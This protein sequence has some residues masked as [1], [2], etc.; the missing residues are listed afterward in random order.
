MLR[1]AVMLANANAALWAI[2]SGLAPTLLITYL[3]IGHGA[4]GLGMSFVLAAPRFAGV[5]RLATPQLM[6]RL[7][8]PKRLCVLAYAASS[9][10]LGVA[11]I[12]PARVSPVPAG[13][14]LAVLVAAWA[15]YQVVEYI[16]TTSLWVWLGRI[17]PLPLRGRLIGVREQWLTRGQIVGAIAGFCLASSRTSPHLLWWL[18]PLDVTALAGAAAMATAVLPLIAMPTGSGVTP[19]TV[20]DAP[21]RKAR[22]LTPEMRNLLV[23]SVLLSFANG[24]AAP[25]RG[26]M[27]YRALGMTY[28]ALLALATVMRLGQ[29]ICAPVL[30]AYADRLGARPVIAWSQAVVVLSPLF[31]LLASPSSPWW[32]AG[33]Y[34]CWIAYAGLNV[35]L[36]LLKL[37]VAP[38]GREARSLALYY[39]ANDLASGATIIAGGLLLQ[40]LLNG[41]TADTSSYTW[42]LALGFAARLTVGLLAPILPSGPQKPAPSVATA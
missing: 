34:A 40:P 7:G 22:V 12:V 21:H 29:S 42:L 16:G 15:A 30:G 37:Q 35:G 41:S 19:A 9:L 28:P 1:R 14:R 23:W 11:A 4:Q 10:L 13:S 38:P 5:L 20:E 8:S 2:G 3:A 17:Y 24:I 32:V 33:A 36:D 31:F 6:N 39:T 26:I 27:P 25:A 18:T